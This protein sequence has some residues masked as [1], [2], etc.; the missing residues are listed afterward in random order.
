MALFFFWTPLIIQVG[1]SAEKVSIR[2]APTQRRNSKNCII[3]FRFLFLSPWSALYCSQE[4]V[5]A[6]SH[7]LNMQQIVPFR[8]QAFFLK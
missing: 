6:R 5:N 7:K 1:T 8:T 3:S 4:L 2:F